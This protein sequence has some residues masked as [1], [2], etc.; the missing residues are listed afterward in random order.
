MAKASFEDPINHLK[1]RRDRTSETYFCY[2]LGQKVVSHYPLH[3]DPK[4]ITAHQRD[5]SSNFARAVQQA[6]TELADPARKAY[7]QQLFDEQKRTAEKPYAILRNFV[8]ASIT[9]QNAQNE[10]I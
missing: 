3:K 9:K 8:I 4:K 2:R 5:L 10:P 7:W 1:G 6:K